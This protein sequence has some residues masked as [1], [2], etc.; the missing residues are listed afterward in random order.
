MTLI[1]RL[2]LPKLTTY[3]ELNLLFRE[4]SSLAIDWDFLGL[5]RGLLHLTPLPLLSGESLELKTFLHHSV[6]LPTVPK[7]A[8]ALSI[9]QTILATRQV[10]L[11]ARKIGAAFSDPVDHATA[12]ELIPAVALRVAAGILEFNHGVAFRARL[13]GFVAFDLGFVVDGRKTLSVLEASLANVFWSIALCAHLELAVS[14]GED[15][16]VRFAVVWLDRLG[17]VTALHAN[18]A[19][20]E[21]HLHGVAV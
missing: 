13:E 19:L 6:L 1:E 5:L 16:A 3:I 17:S 11:F 10:S 4:L 14:A 7:P 20:V 12:A 8:L 9:S 21:R 2:V 18:S 15:A